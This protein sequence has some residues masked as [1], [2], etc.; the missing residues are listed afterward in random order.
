L[1][2]ELTGLHN[3]RGFLTLAEQQ[4]RYALRTQQEAAILFIDLDNMKTINDSAG[5][6][7]GDLALIE[8]AR[9]LKS[10]FRASDIIARI[11]GD[12]F[13]ML[14]LGSGKDEVVTLVGRLQEHLDARNSQ[15]NSHFQ[16][17]MSIGMAFY[18][19]RKPCSLEE[20]LGRADAWMYE[21]KRSR[22]QALN[23]RHTSP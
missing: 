16:L 10:T 4:L 9:L 20:L 5:H 22:K 17:S 12:E 3:R 7:V 14:L 1:N 8:T 18:D 19:P 2:D 15:P 6:Q 23:S 13:A 11:G 21:Q